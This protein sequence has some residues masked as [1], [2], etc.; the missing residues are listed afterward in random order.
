M[1]RSQDIQGFCMFSYPI[2]YQICDVIVNDEY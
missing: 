1:F 2:I